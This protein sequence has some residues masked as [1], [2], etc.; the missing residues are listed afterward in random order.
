MDPQRDALRIAISYAIFSLLWIFSSDYILYLIAQPHAVIQLSIIKGS[1]F[2][3]LT[4]LFLFAVLRL[5]LRSLSDKEESLRIS[6]K[7]FRSLFMELPVGVVLMDANGR[8]LESNPT[9][10]EIFRQPAD[11][12]FIGELHGDLAD[13]RKTQGEFMIRQGDRWIRVLIRRIDGGFLGIF[14]D[15][16]DIKRSEETAR[17]S[18][19][20]NRTL[21]SELH[22]RVKNNLQ[23][24]SSLINL[25]ARGMEHDSCE[26]MRALQ[27]RIRAMALVHELL[28]SNPESSTVNFASYTE[29]L[30]SYLRD[31]YRSSV[32]IEVD[33][34][35]EEFDI[36]TAVPLGLILNELISN[37]LRHA[38]DDVGTVRV[39]LE[40][41]S[42][43]FLLRV[44]DNGR[45]LPEGFSL[46]E[47]A[48][49]GLDIVLGLVR[50][51]DG[52]LTF[53][54]REGTS[55]LIEFRE[56]SYPRRV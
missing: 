28:L 48:G 6:E 42:D 18:L 15:L 56:P 52:T 8:I 14:E 36:E 55:F 3:I 41:T 44:S 33:I 23:I 7:K 38:F 11:N 47:D 45:G 30:I 46:E 26:L 16:T 1:L 21:L 50:Q 51:L 4:S 13:V 37:S 49:L 2:I 9:I 19:E 34:G 5:Y 43:G 27:L 12:R 10:R 29:R 35:E 20:T 25:Q 40:D 22:H 54:S 31:M 24:I 17:R 32:H 53:E 39:S